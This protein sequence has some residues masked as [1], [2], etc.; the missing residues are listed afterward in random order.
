M[1]HVQLSAVV[2]GQAAEHVLH[3]IRQ[4]DRFPALAPHVR[5]TE[6]HPTADGP[7]SSSWE[8][9]FRSGLLT[10]TEEEVIDLAALVIAFAQT[11][12]DFDTFSGAWRIAQAGT[13]CT[14]LFEA[15]FD[16]GIA[17]LEGI[18]DPIAERVIRETAAWAL[19]GLFPDV[20][21]DT[22][23]SRDGTTPVSV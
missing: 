20:T 13:D 11:E 12:G 9:Y 6:I 5:S 14:V 23:P 7:S 3:T 8:L 1:R 10:W 4:W 17:S 21:V 15:D 2:R 18:L 19:V 16:F 22:E